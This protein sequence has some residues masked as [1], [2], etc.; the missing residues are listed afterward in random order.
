MSEHALGSCLLSEV[1]IIHLYV[2]WHSTSALLKHYCPV[3]K[4]FPPVI[5]LS[6]LHFFYSLF[7]LLPLSKAGE[8]GIINTNLWNGLWRWE[9]SIWVWMW[10]IL[11]TLRECYH[12]K[13]KAIYL[14]D[15][16]RKHTHTHT[17]T[18]AR[19][20]QRAEYT[21]IPGDRIQKMS[22]YY[23]WPELSY[24]TQKPIRRPE[25]GFTSPRNCSWIA[26]LLVWF[27]LRNLWYESQSHRVSFFLPLRLTHTHADRGDDLINLPCIV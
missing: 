25:P 23:H 12:H 17:H 24:N 16:L 2:S 6:S 19:W 15:P 9:A 13:A 1:M 18:L 26:T 5:A 27:C 22:G 21:K 3:Y 11:D 20:I 7:S 14:I 8:A 10:L 4:G